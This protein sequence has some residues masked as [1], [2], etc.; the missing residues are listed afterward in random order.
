MSQRFRRSFMQSLF[1]WAAG[2]L[3]QGVRFEHLGDLFYLES[4]ARFHFGVWWSAS[5]RSRFHPLY[6]PMALKAGNSLE[7]FGKSNHLLGYELMRR[8]CPE[9]TL[10]PFAEKSWHP[11]IMTH[12]PSPV[13]RRTAFLGGS[14][15]LSRRISRQTQRTA[16]ERQTEAQMQLRSAGAKPRVVDFGAVLDEFRTKDLDPYVLEPW[17]DVG[18]VGKFL[19]Q[20]HSEL[21]SSRDADNAYRLISALA[22]MNRMEISE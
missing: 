5:S 1:S 17:S 22:W 2:M 19:N 13:T 21:S 3:E 20:S 18:T 7:S 11:S 14:T 6:S 16:I 4:R 9:L 10:L 8:F 12:P 15:D